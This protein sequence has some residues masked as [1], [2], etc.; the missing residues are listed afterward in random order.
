MSFTTVVVIFNE[1]VFIEKNL[2][3]PPTESK[4]FSFIFTHPTRK[5]KCI[6]KK[7]NDDYARKTK[8]L[9]IF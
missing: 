7:P 4:L 1:A 5:T 2:S 8:T 3:D 9:D 6:D